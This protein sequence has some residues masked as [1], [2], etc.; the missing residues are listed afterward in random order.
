MRYSLSDFLQLLDDLLET[1]THVLWGFDEDADPSLSTS[2]SLA[3]VLAWR[4]RRSDLLLAI[5][6][7]VE[8]W[9]L[10]AARHPP[11]QYRIAIDIPPL[12]RRMYQLIVEDGQPPSAVVDLIVL[13]EQMAEALRRAYQQKFG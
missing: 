6:A 12:L 10:C 9:W 8:N 13:R 11:E 4:H 1:A 7:E 5:D 3:A 2:P